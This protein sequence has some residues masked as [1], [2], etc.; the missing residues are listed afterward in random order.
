MRGSKTED[1]CSF[2]LWSRPSQAKAYA[3]S[4]PCSPLSLDNEP[5]FLVTIVLKKANL[6][7]WLI[8]IP[9]WALSCRL[10]LPFGTAALESLKIPTFSA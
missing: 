2:Q 3:V 8:G 1:L 5:S 10:E 9:S 7:E 6:A 4:V